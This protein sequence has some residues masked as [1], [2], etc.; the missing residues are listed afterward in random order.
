MDRKAW[1]VAA[2]TLV[3]FTVVVGASVLHDQRQRLDLSRHTAGA[4]DRSGVQLKTALSL[5]QRGQL[6]EVVAAVSILNTTDQP[7][8]YVGFNCSDPATVTYESTRPIPN[9]PPYPPSAAT[10]RAH[11]MQ[12]RQTFD[13]PLAMFTEDQAAKDP[14]CD[15]SAPPVLVPHKELHY[16]LSNS[17]A[18]PDYPRVDSATTEV[19]TKVQLG[20]LVSTIQPTELV[21]VRSSLSSL[22]TVVKASEAQYERTDQVLGLLLKD[23]AV[24]GWINSQDPTSW[25][26]ART[27]IWTASWSLDAFNTRWAL[28]LH[29]EGDG[30]AIVKVSIP[31]ELAVPRPTTDAI[32]PG[33]A[34][35]HPNGMVPDQDVYAGDLAVLSGKVMVG[36]PVASDGMLTFDYGL[37]PGRYAIHIVTARPRYMGADFAQTAWEALLLSDHDVT[38]WQPAI[39]IGHSASEL[40]SGQLFSFST[41]GGGGGFAS[42]ESMKFMDESLSK[43]LALYDELTARQEANN[44]L[45][46]VLTVD[47]AT[48]AN[49]F[50]CNTG[51]DGGFG[52]LLGL[53]SQNRP[54]AL[55][56]SFGALPLT[57][58]GIS[59]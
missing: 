14:T 56:S 43:D 59:P 4:A 46:A 9:G 1:L 27:S 24:G 41:D 33:A 52:V 32:L 19:V 15:E 26:A 39:P 13:V 5:R 47:P 17:F 21:E 29:V 55:L 54:A 58:S 38:H 30:D 53:D 25:R 2:A 20:R 7:L 12:Y 22:G 40:K 45:G 42:P 23:Q 50:A 18:A 8:N 51:G 44:W 49:V 34:V 3:V 57:F 36:D 31:H 6:T 48:G 16:T 37:A 10:L 35:L 11:M 28:P